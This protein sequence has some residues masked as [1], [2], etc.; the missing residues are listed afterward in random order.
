MGEGAQCDFAIGDVLL[1]DD[2]EALDP[3]RLKVSGP[4]PIISENLKELL[5]NGREVVAEVSGVEIDIRYL[6]VPD[7][8]AIG[9]PRRA[10]SKFGHRRE[11][12]CQVAGV[13][14]LHFQADR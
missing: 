3:E 4:H 13:S 1:V 14:G 7:A 11:A 6:L 8:G 12:A 10:R 9:P 5:P 2:L